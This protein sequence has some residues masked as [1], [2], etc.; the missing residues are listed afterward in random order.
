MVEGS[1]HPHLKALKQLLIFRHESKCFK[2][3]F[4]YPHS[5][6]LAFSILFSPVSLSLLCIL[7]SR[8]LAILW[9]FI[10]WNII[11]DHFRK[12]EDIGH[13]ICIENKTEHGIEWA[14]IFYS[15]LDNSNKKEE[16]RANS[17]REQ[18]HVLL[19]ISF[20]RFPVISSF[21]LFFHFFFAF[22]SL[23]LPSTMSNIQVHISWL[24]LL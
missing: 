20:V 19:S 4:S 23:S 11:L 5:L 12:V 8:T 24:L 6:L 18:N 2:C 9:V 1:R 3:F 10:D 16:R 13:W 22:S 15:L 14:T 21:I 17:K 7:S